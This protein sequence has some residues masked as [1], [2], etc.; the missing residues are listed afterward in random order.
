[1]AATL[2]SDLSDLFQ[3]QALSQAATE[4]GESE[5]S[6]M[7]GFQTA[8]A[9]ILGGLAGKA[10]QT[11]SLRQ[12]FEL[13]TG[14]MNDSSVLSNIRGLFSKSVGSTP[15]GLGSRFLSMLFGGNQSQV[16][17]KVGLASGL[18]PSSASALMTFA[19]PMVL[20]LLGR[21]VSEGHMDMSSFSNFLQRERSG[22]SSMIPAGLSN[23]L[24]TPAA[25]AADVSQAVRSANPGRWL[26]PAIALA[27]VIGLIWYFGL[28]RQ[29]ASNVV[30]QAGQQVRSAAQNVTGFLK[31]SLA[32]GIELNI[33]QN[34]MESRLLAFLKDPSQ[35]LSKTTWFEFDRLTFETNAATLRPES[36]EQLRNVAGILQA[37]PTM[38]VKIGG[39]TDD[40]GD[41]AANVQ[42]SQQRADSVMQQLTGMGI[43]ADRLQAEGYGAQYPVADNSTEAGRAKNRRIA[44][45]VTQ[46]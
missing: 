8:S 3:G 43:S 27:A 4:L 12:I 38:G 5:G 45:Q 46:R 34:G 15:D 40:T 1:M 36:Q 16:A 23:I 19:A 37:Y 41:P 17:E 25:A 14:P 11:G 7:R 31:T 10:G 30:G 9:A 32:N 28:G 21:R 20:G 24:G 13:V 44:L 42:L 33:P 39:Y 35:P 26:W 6:V 2:V 18:K 29:Q 22:I